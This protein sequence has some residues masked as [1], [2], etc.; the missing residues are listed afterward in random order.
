MRWFLVL[1][2]LGLIVCVAGVF[3]LMRPDTKA[4]RPAT[5]PFFSDEQVLLRQVPGDGPAPKFG[6]T[7]IYDPAR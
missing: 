7:P 2:S 4:S 1:T 6:G 5:S 3:L